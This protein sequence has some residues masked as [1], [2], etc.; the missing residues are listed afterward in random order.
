MR[1]CSVV[2]AL[3]ALGA[4]GH[5]FAF[6]AL[7]SPAEPRQKAELSDTE[8]VGRATQAV[9][10]GAYSEA[11]AHFERLSDHG[12]LNP[13]SSYN[14]A[15]AYLQRAESSKQ[16]AGDLG[17]A[18]AGFREAA[19]LD[20]S[21]RDAELRLAAVRQEISRAR[22]RAGKDPV[23]VQPE[24]GRAIVGLLE[25]ELWGL[26][27]ALGSFSLSLGLVLRRSADAP[28]KLAGSIAMY[29]G[30]VV[31]VVFGSLTLSALNYRTSSQEAVVVVDEAKLLSEQAEALTAKALGVDAT[32]IPEGASVY[33]TAQRGTLLRVNWGTVQAW[34]KRGDLRPLGPGQPMSD[35]F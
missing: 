34:V 22:A 30:A 20:P 3:G 28:R 2:C 11:I 26:V 8:L 24:L 27:A 23:V 9:T 29:A 31:L 1:L 19:L 32:A 15:I 33:V 16:R 6:S 21:D 5:A 10:R 13:D 18:A 14:R 7:G 12:H 4:L 35:G 25:E 17:Q